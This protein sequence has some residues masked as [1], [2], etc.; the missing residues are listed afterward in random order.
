MYRP[1]AQTGG[2]GAVMPP[3]GVVLPPGTYTRQT[4]VL[5]SMA[6]L[7]P[8]TDRYYDLTRKPSEGGRLRLP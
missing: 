1:S 4:H 8:A 5:C 7:V 3:L 6:E 2:F